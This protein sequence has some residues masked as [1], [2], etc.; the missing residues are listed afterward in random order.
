MSPRQCKES[1]FVGEAGG[2]EPSDIE[3]LGTGSALPLIAAH[4]AISSSLDIQTAL[5]TLGRE[6]LK[7]TGAGVSYVSLLDGD[8]L[9]LI[10]VWVPSGEVQWE[11][12]WVLSAT[13]SLT[14]RAMRLRRPA[15]WA[16]AY[17]LAENLD[18]DMTH[19]RNWKY[20]GVPLFDEEEAVGGLVL[21]HEDDSIYEADKVL[22]AEVLAAT[23]STAIHHA[24]VF[25]QSIQMGQRLAEERIAS[26]LHDSVAQSVFA[27]GMK[28]EELLR[29]AEL[30]PRTASA[31]ND[32][33]SVVSDARYQLREALFAN[34]NS[35]PE[36]P[37][38]MLQAEVQHHLERGGVPVTLIIGEA[39]PPLPDEVRE[40]IRLVVHE[41]LTN[42]R[43]HS[44]A[45]AVVVKLSSGVATARVTIQDNGVGLHASESEKTAAAG[46]HFGLP[47]LRRLVEHLGGTFAVENSEDV[48]VTVSATFALAIG[49]RL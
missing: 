37:D 48:G 1:G 20:L 28:I 9:P 49:G 41:A 4:Q 44:K 3:T 2:I 25:D 13:T 26:D 16:R 7:V 47:N 6:A 23:S 21:G 45:S 24:R 40:V 15:R 38:D 17:R 10:S 31:L 30:P 14:A 18:F 5:R 29:D 46:L 35:Q 36:A 42:V 43:K 33:Q 32:L 39:M 19:M 22:I 27:I 12:Q 34:R 11:K 8:R